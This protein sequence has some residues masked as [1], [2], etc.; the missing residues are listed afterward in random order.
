MSLGGEQTVCIC[1]NGNGCRGFVF[2]YAGLNWEGESKKRNQLQ[3][4]ES[5]LLKTLSVN[6]A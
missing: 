2:M 4:Q 1:G 5:L 6:F 3:E